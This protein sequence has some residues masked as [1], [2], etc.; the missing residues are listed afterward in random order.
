M[1]RQT[2]NEPAPTRRAPLL[3]MG[4]GATIVFM[5]GLCAPLVWYTGQLHESH[6]PI[7]NIA[8]LPPLELLLA[9]GLL[10]LPFVVLKLL[11]IDWQIER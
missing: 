9:V 1:D 8:G 10:A 2:S 7:A 4:T 3:P 5:L 11:R 6:G